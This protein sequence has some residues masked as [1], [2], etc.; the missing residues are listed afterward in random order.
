MLIN[1][2]CMLFRKSFLMIFYFVSIERVI[3][4]FEKKDF[5][6]VPVSDVR[7]I[8]DPRKNMIIIYAYAK[9]TDTVSVGAFVVDGLK[10]KCSKR[11]QNMIFKMVK[12]TNMRNM[13]IYEY[14]AVAGR[15]EERTG[16][17]K[18]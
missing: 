4:S 16:K 5:L 12:E 10:L 7:G 11:I 18:N 1:I 9:H 8:I 6:C 3:K 17:R 13:R 14:V 15:N 2:E